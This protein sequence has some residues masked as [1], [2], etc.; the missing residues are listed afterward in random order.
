MNDRM[1][2]SAAPFADRLM[3]G[4]KVIWRGRPR[5]GLMLTR[6][7]SF[8]IPFS[9]LWGCFSIFWETSV[10]RAPNAPVVM[11]LF[12]IPF[13]LMGLFLIFGR[14]FFDAW[15]RKGISYALTDRRAL[16]LRLR[17]SA[18][19]QSVSLERL[20]EATLNETSNG[21]GTIRFGPAVQLWNNRGAGGFGLWI[22]A[23]DRTPQF[24]SIDD[25]KKV[26][27]TIQE[28]AQAGGS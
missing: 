21:R 13:V 23:L 6:S 18:S 10:L 26:F 17:P 16:I 24:F 25:A 7:D 15:V 11:V 28:R 3:R 4:E 1:L 14:F 8:L 19:F 20:S 27:A 12:G 9:L 2:G 5:Q 22:A